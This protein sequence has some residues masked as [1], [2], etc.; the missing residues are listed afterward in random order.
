MND[1]NYYGV[2]FAHPIRIEPET[3]R[4]SLVG[5]IKVVAQAIRQLLRTEPGERLM[6]QDYGCDLRRYLFAPNTTATRRLIAEE[7]SA[8]I[9]RFE[10]RVLLGAVEVTAD[11]TEPAQ[12]NIVINYTLRRTGAPGTVEHSLL[13][14]G[15]RS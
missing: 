8:S 15:D 7:I 4:F 13:L 11:P 10:D 6:R 1:R 9:L 2:G 12:V 3:G 14:N 5:D